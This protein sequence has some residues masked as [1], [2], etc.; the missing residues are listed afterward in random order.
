MSQFNQLIRASYCL[1]HLSWEG[2]HT[3]H[4]LVFCLLIV[5][6]NRL[7][8]KY[9]ITKESITIYLFSWCLI[10]KYCCYLFKE[11]NDNHN[12]ENDNN[13]IINS[14]RKEKNLEDLR[15]GLSMWNK[16]PEHSKPSR[17]MWIKKC[18]NET[19]RALANLPAIYY[20]I[21]KQSKFSLGESME[22]TV[23]AWHFY[24]LLCY[25]WH[26]MTVS[27]GIHDE[28]WRWKVSLSISICQFHVLLLVHDVNI[29]KS[30]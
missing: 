4:A 26:K 20:Q 23:I 18:H 16:C 24:Y 28:K 22:A 6:T 15:K 2:K 13:L 8:C 1:T 5:F 3:C 17:V 21:R 19:F 14:I 25:L 11:N 7:L 29:D 12:G 30:A 10:P 9:W 27:F